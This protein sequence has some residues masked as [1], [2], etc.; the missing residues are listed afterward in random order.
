MNEN[1]RKFYE[2]LYSSE[3]TQDNSE[4]K[5]FLNRINILNAP[6]ALCANLEKDITVGEISAAIDSMKTGKTP[7]PATN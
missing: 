3:I 4:L 6:E 2:G 1:F 7:G 5:V